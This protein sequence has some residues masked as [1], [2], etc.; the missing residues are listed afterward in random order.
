MFDFRKHQAEYAERRVA[1]IPVR[2][3]RPLVKHPQKFGLPGSTDLAQ[4]RTFSACTGLGFYA[5]QYSRVTVLDIDAADENL[6]ADSLI[7]HGSTPLIVLTASE[8]FHCYYRHG[9][10]GRRIRPWGRE[11]PID[12]IGKGLVIAAPSERQLGR[13]EIINGT[14]DDLAHLPPMLNPPPA[15]PD[16]PRLRPNQSPERD[17]Q[18]TEGRRN[19]SL[20]ATC[21]KF[22]S[23]CA[24]LHQLLD[25]ARMLNQK[26]LPP[27]PDAEVAAT[28]ASAWKYR[29]RVADI[30]AL[31]ADP[32]ALS[33]LQW[34][35]VHN[36]PNAEFMVANGLENLL[37]WPRLRFYQARQ[38][39]IDEGRIT[40]VRGRGRALAARY[41]WPR[42]GEMK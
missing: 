4:R 18:I 32:H 31:V 42:G 2:D 17:E 26:F 28:A 7:K 8:K 24:N 35:Q 38:R 37:G 5:G 22:A 30:D 25:H 27:L 14:L 21:M 13:Y 36:G 20:F 40:K 39:L 29:M 1:T 6:L 19:D 34:L 33:L 23:S 9:G 10:E 16:R 15:K 12:V 3:K 11:L 41:R